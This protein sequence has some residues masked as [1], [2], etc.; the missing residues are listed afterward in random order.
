MKSIVASLFAAFVGFSVPPSIAAC[1]DG[2]IPS[3]A[4]QEI[5]LVDDGTVFDATTGLMWMR[6]SI[7]QHWQDET[8]VAGPADTAQFF[9]WADALRHA[10]G[11]TFAGYQDWR[12]PNK[13]ELESI[14]ERSC[15]DPA[16][17]ERVF[18]NSAV[19]GYWSNSP[20]NFNDAF[21]WA[22]NFADGD[23]ITS[24]RTNLLSVR[25]VR[26]VAQTP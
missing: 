14:V 4:A 7:G 3:F 19:N 17:N 5:V 10:Q 18:P 8:C 25:L 21:A 12:L 11:Y 22:I 20:N 6:C 26:E 9:T 24:R 15:Y 23:H 1:H 16:I 13:N 2:L